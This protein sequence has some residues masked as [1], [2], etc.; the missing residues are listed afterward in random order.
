VDAF[1]YSNGP[2]LEHVDAS[3]ALTAFTAVMMSALMAAGLILRPQRHAVMRLAWVSLG[4]FML[5]V[6]NSWIIFGHAQ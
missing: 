2:L 3:H 1:V 5:H 4:L 6:L